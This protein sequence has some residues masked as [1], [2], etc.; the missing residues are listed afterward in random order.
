M[1]FYDALWALILNLFVDLTASR[2]LLAPSDPEWPST[3]IWSGLNETVGGKLLA[4]I[5]IAAS[6]HDRFAQYTSNLSTYNGSVCDALRSTWFYPETHLSSPSSPMA[7]SFTNNSCNPWVERDVPCTIGYDVAYTI[8]A[9]QISDLRHGLEFAKDHKIRL[10][11][12]NTGHDYLGKSTGAHALGLW[13]HQLK[14]LE[15][16]TYNTTNYTGPAIR[17]GAG[18]LAIEAYRFASSHGLMVVGGNCPTVGIAGGYSQ[19]GG[20]GPLISKYGM[21]ADQVLEWDVLTADGNIVTANATSHSDLFWALR[22]GG[23]GTFGVVVSMTVKAFPDIYV[24][25][26]SLTAVD[27]GTNTDIIYDFM[28]SWLRALP[29]I[30]DA[31]VHALWFIGPSGFSLVPAFA[32]G[33]HK[34]ELDAL[35]QVPIEEMKK[36]GLHYQYSSNESA[37]FLSAYESL[38]TGCNVSDYNIGGRLIP[39]SLVLS[40]TDRLVEAIRYI[41]SEAIL[42]GVSF[43]ARA[44]VISPDEVAV[45]PYFRKAL[46]NAFIGV[47]INYTSWTANQATLDA[48]TTDLLPA[49]EV[50]TPHGGVY[51]NEADSRQPDFQSTF[52]RD[53]Y[54]R[55]L[56]I[57]RLYDPDNIFYAKIAV[58]S[59]AW[60]QQLDK[61]LC[62]LE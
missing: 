12:R 44:G 28:K 22:G 37:T 58:G 38:A 2:C 36:A 14:L 18:V 30:V 56:Q 60:E 11:I 25:T 15:V 27:N 39:R 9:T 46:F 50:L 1:R 19:G 35:L 48:I 7:Y 24:S 49:L 4:T 53:H 23:G 32:P 45:N 20:H 6:C 47:P 54:D 10:I 43:N 21:G 55:L 34:D 26:A 41:G 62:S 51:L 52:Y 29:Q 13:T 33:L 5:P 8:N 61:R 42:S 57:K 31:G 40:Q 17:I 16:G 59:E 3:A